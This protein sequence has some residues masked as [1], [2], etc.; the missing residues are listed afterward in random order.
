MNDPNT[1]ISKLVHLVEEARTAQSHLIAKSRDYADAIAEELGIK[2]QLTWGKLVAPP[3]FMQ[4]GDDA[5]LSED[6]WLTRALQVPVANLTVPFA[7]GVKLHGHGQGHLTRMAGLAAEY[8]M[9]PEQ[10][11]KLFY[12]DAVRHIARLLRKALGYPAQ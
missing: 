12:T 1:P 5:Y 7:F 9:L 3:T 11:R 2:H 4:A 8:D 6:G 10:S